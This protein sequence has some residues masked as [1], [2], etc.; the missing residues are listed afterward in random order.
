MATHVKHDPHEHAH[1]AGCGHS[2]MEHDGHTDYLHDGH[3]HHRHE[4]HVD[5]HE[6]AASNAN[7]ASCSGGHK[8]EGHDTSHHHARGCGHQSV[9]HA[10]HVDYAVGGHL[11][12]R[13]GEHCDDHGAVKIA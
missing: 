4:D 11:H 12:N 5:E 1:K 2:G 9:P 8:C 13:H 10:G 7:P 6:V 3:L